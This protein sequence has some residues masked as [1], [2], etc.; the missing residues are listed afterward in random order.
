MRGSFAVSGNR[1]WL[2]GLVASDGAWLTWLISWLEWLAWLAGDC[3]PDPLTMSIFVSI[4]LQ[5][6]HCPFE[7]TLTPPL[8]ILGVKRK[9]MHLVICSRH[10]SYCSASSI[11]D[12]R[13]Y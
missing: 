2:E 9:L 4:C 7:L 12:E 10:L 3:N 13:P 11:Y 1:R 6:F 8:L 5:V